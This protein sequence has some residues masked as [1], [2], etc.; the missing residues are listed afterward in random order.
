MK[1]RLTAKL[2][3]PIV[4]CTL[5][6]FSDAFSQGY[7]LELDGTNDYINLGTNSTIKAGDYV[8]VE[9]W[10]HASNW[11]SLSD[12][13]LIGNEHNSAGWQIKVNAAGSEIQGWLWRDGNLAKPG[14]A[15][16]SLSAGWHHFAMTYDSR[17]TKFYVD[18]VLRDTDDAYGN[19]PI[20]D[21]PTNST[22]IGAD[23][24]NGG[25]PQTSFQGGPDYFQGKIEEVRIWDEALSVITLRDWI[26]RELTTSHPN[27][28]N[29]VSDDLKAYYKMTD[30]TG[31]ALS[32]NSANSIT[33][34]LNNMDNGDWINSTAP[35][36]YITALTGNWNTA[37]SWVSTSVPNSD[38][39]IVLINHDINID[40]DANM[41]NLTISTS[42]TLTVNAEK[43]L[44]IGGIITNYGTLNVKENASFIDNGSVSGSGTFTIERP[45]SGG[46]WHYVSAPISHPTADLFWGSALYEFDETS[47]S[48]VSKK[49]GDN[50]SICKGYDA[51][52]KPTAAGV[53]SYSGTFITGNQS[54]SISYTGAAGEGWNLVGNP[55]PS[56]LDWDA[57]SGWTKSNV[58]NAVYVWNPDISNVT[59]YVGG[60]GTNGGTRYVAPSQGFFVRVNTGGGSIAMTNST[61]THT[62]ATSFRQNAKDNMLKLKISGNG[63][64]DEAIVCF[65]PYATD[66]F[67]GNYDA[68]KVKSF[69]ILTPQ[70]YTRS[71]DLEELSIN[72]F[73]GLNE[74]VSIPL[75][76][77]VGSTGD[78]EISVNV[79]EFDEY[80]QLYLE[81]LQDGQIY[82]LQQE[83]KLNFKLDVHDNPE[84]FIIH[85]TPLQTVETQTTNGID[86]SEKENLN[87]YSNNKHVYIDIYELE[88]AQVSIYNMLGDEIYNGSLTT[89]MNKVNLDNTPGGYYIV[90]VKDSEYDYSQ[91]IV[92][93]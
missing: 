6:S 3:L 74:N 47:A 73:A 86:E 1:N 26:H 30:G 19:N 27:Y 15:L 28:S 62:T 20:D 5:L 76:A 54:T 64:S 46:G 33:G 34:T 8:T 89:S 81:D 75:I 7:S 2:L 48:W 12:G 59:T 78:Y 38:W 49:A 10:A 65:D 77:E 29:S 68:F 23:V 61:R 88:H 56:F 90:N 57:S 91:K 24:A 79:A 43:S 92:I 37:T 22:L 31:T 84:R 87:I 51:Y 11:S 93:R 18:G 35:V 67:D 71:A 25:F 44:T 53:V 52:Y 32:D 21:N 9:V 85:F 63:Y 72:T 17:Y 69:N 50:L 16:S 82:D 42:K 70:I 60:V 55:Y 39:A 40:A 36:P 45:I 83:S 66:D 80:T 41:M 14:Y 13:T 4:L 58:N